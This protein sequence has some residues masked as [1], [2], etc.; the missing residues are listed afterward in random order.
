MNH[1]PSVPETGNSNR[2]DLIAIAGERY[3]ARGMFDWIMKGWPMLPKRH[4]QKEANGEK[5]YYISVMKR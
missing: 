4:Q 1:E 3:G 2:I 5:E